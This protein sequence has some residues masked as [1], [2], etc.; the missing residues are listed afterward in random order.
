MVF[1]TCKMSNHSF[2]FGR[3]KR[4]KEININSSQSLSASP[5]SRLCSALSIVSYS[6]SSI[7]TPD[8]ASLLASLSSLLD[9]PE[10]DLFL[11]LFSSFTSGVLDWLLSLRPLS[12]SPTLR[13]RLPSLLILGDALF[14]FSLLLSLLESLL[15]ELSLPASS[16]RE[17]SLLESFFL[18]SSLRESSL[19]DSVRLASSLLE[20]SLLESSL[21]ES[22]L[23]ESSLLEL[24]L[25]LLRS[26]LTSLS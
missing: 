12:R 13:S 15:L 21:L 11:L 9:L 17:S 10:P 20:S 2:L 26:L 22:S 6:S 23:L 7:S 4:S 8:P 25:S 1:L 14:R 19:L 24:P 16:L 3:E 18:D 5:L